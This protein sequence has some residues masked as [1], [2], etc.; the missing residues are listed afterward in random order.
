MSIMKKLNPITIP[1]VNPNEPD[2][3]LAA[4]E[5]AE[6]QQVEPGQVIALVETTK[7]TAE[8][9]ADTSGYLVG[10]QYAVGDTLHAGD[11]LAYIGVSPDSQ[12]P[13]LPPWSGDTASMETHPVKVTGLR[14]TKPA[15]ELALAQGVDLD[16][17]PQGALVTQ[18]MIQ[19]MLNARQPAELA[20]IP[21]GEKRLVIYGA[22]GH[23]RS[24]AALIRTLGTYDLVGF[25]DDGV[26]AGQMVLR[27]PVLGGGDELKNLAREG[28]RLAVNGIGGIAD[29]SV[30]LSAFERLRAAGF[31]CPGVVHPTAFIEDS[32]ELEDGTQVFPFAY[33][34]TEVVVGYG[35]IVNT[36]AIV[37][38]N[39]LLSRYVNLSP[40][41]TL[42]GGVSVG[43]ES[44]VGMQATVNLNVRIGKG[45][46]IGNG[47]TVK[48]DVPD[49]GIVPAGTIWPP[50]HR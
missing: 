44:L 9:L 36:G 13:R 50:R 29:L 48:A 23:G 28:V 8:I 2:A 27:L 6:G 18:A 26:D 45:A 10:L 12:D 47:A 14:I 49:G 30:R 5:A 25:L 15:R 37:S 20:P 31:H 46:Q 7:S 3:L 19:E 41:A 32:A 42:A 33:V 24:L 39:C 21:E 16:D 38:H 1:L 34:G 4:L 43:E 22:G 11:V 17:L 40:G 35:C